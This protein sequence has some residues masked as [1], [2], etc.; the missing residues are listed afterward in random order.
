MGKTRQQKEK[1]N[2]ERMQKKKTTEKKIRA[3][4]MEIEKKD[5]KQ[6]AEVVITAGKRT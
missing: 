2:C 3:V 5:E 4:I 1:K 6:K